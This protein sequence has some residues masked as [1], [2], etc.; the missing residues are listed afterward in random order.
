M[1]IVELSMEVKMDKR[2]LNGK[3]KI[4]SSGNERNI[5]LVA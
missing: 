1:S 4:S 2:K 3:L 5:F